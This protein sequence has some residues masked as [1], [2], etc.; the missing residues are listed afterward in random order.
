MHEIAEY[1]FTAETQST[2]S[3]FF[4]SY[5]TLAVNLSRFFSR[6]RPE[7][8]KVFATL[9]SLRT[10]RLRGD[11][12]LFLHPVNILTKLWLEAFDVQA[13]HTVDAKLAQ[14]ARIAGAQRVFLFGRE[15]IVAH[16]LFKI[17]QRSLINRLVHF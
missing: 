14:L 17:L 4:L 16:H 7:A 12:A 11:T 5:A 15:I 10:P 3:K 9:S 8:P 2:Q 1:D 13:E 6:Q